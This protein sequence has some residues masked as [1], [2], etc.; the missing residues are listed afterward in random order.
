M[1][2]LDCSLCCDTFRAPKTLPCLHS[3][4][5]ECLEIFIER[6]HSSQKLTCPVCRTPFT[7]KV[8]Q[9]SKLKTLPLL[10]SALKA[11]SSLESLGFGNRNQNIK[12]QDEEND[13]RY[14]CIDCEVYLCDFC[15]KSHKKFPKTMNDNLIPLSET[16]SEKIA[17]GLQSKLKVNCETH[18]QKEI[19]LF[20]KQCKIA[21]CSLCIS[22]HKDHQ[23]TPLQDEM[24]SEKKKISEIIKKVLFLFIY[25]FFINDLIFSVIDLYIHIKNRLRKK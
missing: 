20:C 21:L 24:K 18:K 16:S 8:N 6:N 3:F 10:E 7:L 22:G 1:S 9:I 14:F 11:Q 5:S 13:A 23:I 17:V 2:D 12:C 25:F 4:C 15:F 19:D